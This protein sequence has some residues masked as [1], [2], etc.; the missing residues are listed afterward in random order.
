MLY[1]MLKGSNVRLN[2]I[3]FDLYSKTEEKQWIIYHEK[4]IKGNINMK[5]V[6]SM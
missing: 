3:L 1:L 5:T 2:I 4:Y 6:N